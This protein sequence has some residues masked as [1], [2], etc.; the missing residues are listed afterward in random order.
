MRVLLHP[1]LRFHNL[2]GISGSDQHLGEEAVGIKCDRR[3]QI[4]QLVRRERLCL[5]RRR[6]GRCMCALPVKG[7]KMNATAPVRQ[8]IMSNSASL[9]SPFLLASDFQL[10]GAV[11]EALLGHAQHVQQRQHRVRHR[12]AGLE[13]KMAAALQLAGRAARHK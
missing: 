7:I 10:P 2:K 4:G 3:Y 5:R 8:T 13:F 9:L 11:A 12:R 6:L 1:R